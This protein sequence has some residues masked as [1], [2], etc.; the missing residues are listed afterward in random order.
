MGYGKEESQGRVR[1]RMLSSSLGL[2]GC[3]G[4]GKVAYTVRSPV[5]FAGETQFTLPY[6]QAGGWGA[7]GRGLRG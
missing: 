1:E 4:W 7:M 2:G 3:W 6:G 5:P